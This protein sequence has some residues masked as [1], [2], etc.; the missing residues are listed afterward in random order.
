MNVLKGFFSPIRDKFYAIS[1]IMIL[2]FIVSEISKLSMFLMQYNFNFNLISILAV[3]AEIETLLK[4]PW[5]IFTH[6]FIH[7]DIYHLLRNLIFFL[8][9]RN[10]YSKISEE[11]KIITI[12]FLSGIFSCLIFIFFYNTFPLLATRIDD[13]LIGSSS[14]ILGLF[15]LYT[16]KYPN[17]QINFYFLQINSKYLLI[18]IALFSLVSIP[19]FNTGGNISHIGGITFGFLYHLLNKS[20][21]QIKRSSLTN[22]QIFRDKKRIKEKEV[23]DIL[24]KISQSGFESLTNVEKNKLF[25][26]SKK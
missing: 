16:F 26:Q 4:K 21:I 15:S 5:S 14:A 17:N 25:E 24:E 9:V 22:D 8:I 19:Q 10:L 3:P 20:E 12:F 2:I 1:L 7:E 13:D 6:I 18:V 11:F 23:D